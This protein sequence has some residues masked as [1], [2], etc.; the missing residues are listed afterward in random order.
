MK[1]STCKGAEETQNSVA[2]G[3]G[4]VSRASLDPSVGCG[5]ASWRSHRWRKRRGFVLLEARGGSGGHL[6]RESRRSRGG[7]LEAIGIGGGRSWVRGALAAASD[8]LE[9]DA[10]AAPQGD[11]T[12]GGGGEAAVAPQGDNTRGGGGGGGSTRR[13]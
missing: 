6:T 3:S 10:A 13:R 1:D 12:G 2:V 11:N 8:G 4:A 5:R 9:G 7:A